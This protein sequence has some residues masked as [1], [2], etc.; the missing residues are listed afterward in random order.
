[1]S[2]QQNSPFTLLTGASTIY[3]NRLVKLSSGLVVHNTATATDVPV[4][5]TQIAQ[6]TSGQPITVRDI[7]TGGTAQV[8]AAGAI[9]KGADIFAAANGKDERLFYTIFRQDASDGRNLLN[10]SE[11]RAYRKMHDID[12]CCFDAEVPADFLP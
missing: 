5:V 7:K 8:T 3:A 12:L 4:G 9:S 1:M 6:A 10:R 11:S 2:K